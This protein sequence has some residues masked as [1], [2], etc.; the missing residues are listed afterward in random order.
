MLARCIKLD[1]DCADIC[2]EGARLIQRNSEIAQ[3]FMSL[4]EKICTMCGDECQK[5]THMK[6]CQQCAESCRKCVEECRNYHTA[7][8]TDREMM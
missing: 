6:H 1:M 2:Y 7:N 8:V 4:C 5:H 3:Q